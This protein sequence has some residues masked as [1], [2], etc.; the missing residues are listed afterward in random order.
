MTRSK[1]KQPKRYL[2][3]EVLAFLR[4]N[5]QKA[6]NYKQLGSAME[7]ENE[8]DRFALLETLEEL[9]HQGF[10]TE[11][12][13]G[14]Y[15]AKENK[16]YETGTID[17]TTQ[18][19]AFVVISPE[20]P[21]VFIP[22]RKTRDALQG[23]L[24]KIEVQPQ[25]GRAKPEGEVV[26]VIERKKTKYVGTIQINPKF[27]F[28]VPD[29]TKIHV[30]F[31]VPI[32]DINGAKNGQKVLVELTDWKKGSEN[33]N[34]KVIDV[35]GTAGEHETEIN[36]IMAEFGLPMVF[37]PEVEAA[38]KKLATEI[39]P[40]EIARRRD[41]R[42][43][44]TF[45]IDPVDAKDFDDALSLQKLENGNWEVGVHIADVTHYLKPGTILD[46]EAVSRAT[47]VYLVDRCVPMLPEILSNFAC[48]LRPQ[49]EKYCFS[50]VFEMDDQAQ[51]QNQWFGKTVIYSDHRFSYEEVQTIIETE[52]GPFKEEILTLDRLA[53]ILRAERTSKG[54]IFFDKAEVK[55]QLDDKGVPTGVY[56]KT[57]KDAHKLIEDFML[58]A[59]RKVAEFLGKKGKDDQPKNRDK[60]VKNEKGSDAVVYRIHDV[61]KDEK[62]F[63]LNNFVERF[64]YSVA[65]GNK[66]KTA[67]SI[68]KL[69]QDVK[70]KK[71][72]SMIELLAV[73]SMPKAIYTTKNVGHY[74]LGF[75][76]YTHFTSPI[77][78]YPDVMVHRLLEAKLQHTH[79]L[80][81]DELELLCKHS[82]EME[83]LASDAERASVKYKQVEF[84]EN[85]IGEEFDGVISGVTEWG[86]FVEI[87]ENKCEGRV[88][89][90]DMKDDQYVFD[91]E[92]YRVVGRRTGRVYTLGD[93]VRISVKRADLIKK[94]L[95]FEFVSG[96]SSK[97]EPEI[98]NPKRYKKRK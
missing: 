83:K 14:K 67:Q 1:K 24:V 8:G 88:S 44:T 55:F 56:F 27:A 11:K 68:N 50:A 65:V 87:I 19:T 92:N 84:L 54:S 42:K 26:E 58:L 5:N 45:T 91:E 97:Q 51:I 64:G 69:L 6:F 10:V 86:I 49:E 38:A 63:E 61:P 43:I 60:K 47:S 2:F 89:M 85:K 82:S 90:R 57:Q 35:L 28:V 76:Y 78:R 94:Q 53:K 37:A 4:H 96:I 12:E 39:T 41:F 71:E 75:D 9:K 40:E 17:F 32:H 66:T 16:I 20:L 73:R 21:D 48:S 70:N 36:A 22:F 31:F 7:I 3:E 46:D 23:D 77:R 30:D 81:A 25:R 72:Q 13:I 79:Y 33:P 18:G 95:D 59:N 80:K 62:L 98:R 93:K 74:G 29:Y 15:Q 34:G 52:E